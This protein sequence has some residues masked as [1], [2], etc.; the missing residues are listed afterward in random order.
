MECKKIT[1]RSAALLG[2]R[3]SDLLYDLILLEDI[4]QVVEAMSIFGKETPDAGN[5]AGIQRQNK[6]L[7]KDGTNMRVSLTVFGT[8]EQ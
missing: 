2:V 3:W 1:Q 8:G 7:P 4:C 6:C 5:V